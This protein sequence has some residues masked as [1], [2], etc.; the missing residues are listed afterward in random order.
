MSGRFS[1][2]LDSL[3]S[4]IYQCRNKDVSCLASEILRGRDRTAVLIGSGGSAISAE[5]FR[6]CRETFSFSQSNVETPM[7]FVSEMSGLQDSDVWLFTAGAENA[8]VMAAAQSAYRRGASQIN[9]I[10]RNP[11]GRSA[12]Y[13]QELGGQVFS[14]PVSEEK[15]G[16]L[17]THSLV[18]TI[19][20]LLLAFDTLTDVPFGDDLMNR[21]TAAVNAELDSEAREN[22]RR[23][24]SALGAND[25]L[26]VLAEPQLFP[27]SRLIDT[28]VWEAAICN[29]QST[30]FRNFAHGRHTWI[31]HRPKQ[32]FVLALTGQDLPS[33]H[34]SVLSLIPPSVRR[35]D[36][37]FGNCGRLENAVG[38]VR[39]LVL[40]EAMG[41]AVQIDPGRPGVGSFGQDI[42]NDEALHFASKTMVSAV[43]H[44]YASVLKQ[45]IPGTSTM[46]FSDIHKGRVKTI[47]NKAI[48]AI[49]LD[50]DGTIVSTDERLAP[51]DNEIIDQLIRLRELGVILAFATGRGGSAGE[52]LRRIFDTKA[53]RDII[54][55]YYNGAYLQSLNVNID[56][57]RPNPDPDIDDAI[58]WMGDNTHQF[59]R[60]EKP[61]RGVQVAIQ[62]DNLV[63]PNQFEQAISTCPPLASNRLRLDRSAHS[64]DLVI[65][66][67]SKLS[68][69]KATEVKILDGTY[70]LCLGDS[71]TIFGNDHDLLSHPWG[72]S[73]DAVC[74]DPDGSWSLFGYEI[75]GPDALLRILTSLTPSVGGV[76]HF[77]SDTLNLDN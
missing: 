77:A 45:D 19:T 52:E 24:F 74:C 61:K 51:P 43:R 55:G 15:D 29:V 46:Q 33:V 23:S 71:G 5:Y 17:A 10:T 70:I 50:Y 35:I 56:E 72:I 4:T 67:A 76:V 40:I 26:L 16:F 11:H 59:H 3:P 18:S 60:F 58:A 7:Q 22:E 36:V 38:I 37:D 41:D 64:Y 30:D 1:A 2:K 49:V 9:M 32:S 47:E 8:D 27:I 65:A 42:Y 6:R 13:L 57:S 44:K 69:V 12:Q 28:S 34:T 20:N 66:N 31:H 21:F 75:S 39:G 68:V 63:S 54:V 48:G 53:Q 25:T 62:M 73:V 14:V